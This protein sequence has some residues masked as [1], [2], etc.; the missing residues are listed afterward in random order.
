[1]NDNSV[2][3]LGVKGGPAIRPGSSMPSSTLVRL[4]GQTIL[5]DAG[6]GCTA[7]LVRA[8]VALTEIDAILVTHLHSD[9]YLELGPLLHT[10]WT[11]GLKRPVPVH[12]PAGLDTYWEAFL[13]SMAH[14]IDTRIAD[15][16][17]PDPAP[18]AALQVLDDT[19][20]L[21][22]GPVSVTA[23]RN[24]HPPITDSYA[25]RL[26]TRD[27]AVVLSGDTAPMP[28]MAAFASNADLLVHEAMLPAGVRTIVARM[29]YPDDRLQ[30]HILRS[31]T[32]AAEAARIAAQ[33]GVKSLALHHLI[34]DNDAGMTRADWQA[35][36]APHFAGPLHIGEDGLTIALEGEAA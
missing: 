36:V 14:D 16:G 20:T 34:P 4:A 2:T 29:G 1:M 25:L 19:T 31:H 6:L 21:H 17:R 3:L 15:E 12:G 35:A 26:A 18:L 10:A 11:A 23:L 22:I 27:H 5:V 30:Q 13:A 32:P 24:D 28:G 9:H 8:G 7:G 33:A